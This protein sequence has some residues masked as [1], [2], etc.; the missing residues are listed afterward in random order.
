MNLDVV[1]KLQELGQTVQDAYD[2]VKTVYVDNKELTKKNEAKLREIATI[3]G[4]AAEAIL[5]AI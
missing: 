1:A 3:T 4:N 5:A 2:A